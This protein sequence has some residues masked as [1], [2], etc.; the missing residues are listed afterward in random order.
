MS[1]TE[2]FK[3]TKT[4]NVKKFDEVHNSWRGAMSIWRILEERYLPSLPSPN[5]LKESEPRY[6]SRCGFDG[7]MS[8]IWKLPFST[9]MTEIE[10]IVMLSTFDWVIVNRSNILKIINAFREFDGETSLKEQADLI[11]T[12]YKKDKKFIG[13]CWN[14]T[15]INGD[16]WK[17]SDWKPYNVLRNNKH[18]E[19]FSELEKK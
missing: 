16:T 9:K 13:I 18:W 3:I 11:E 8:E 1:Y 2:L 7:D 5:W 17:D 14:Q 6:Y 12:L 15:S 10:N 19:L 4:G